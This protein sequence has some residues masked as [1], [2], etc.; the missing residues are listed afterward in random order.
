MCYFSEKVAR[1]TPQTYPIEG[2]DDVCLIERTKETASYLQSWEGIS[3]KFE[4]TPQNLGEGEKQYWDI[5]SSTAADATGKLIKKIGTSFVQVNIPTGLSDDIEVTV[6]SGGITVTNN[7]HL[8][9]G[10]TLEFTA[11]YKASDSTPT[12]YEWRFDG[13][14]Q[15]DFTSN[16][17]T[18]NTS[19]LVPGTYDIYLEVT[20]EFQR[21]YSYTAQVKVSN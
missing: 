5:D 9:G 18:L 16:T 20:D 7:T 10:S 15:E 8:T 1:L 11:N 19:N 4:I 2:G 21:Y 3:N 12:A 14:L 6:I 13:V 17:Y